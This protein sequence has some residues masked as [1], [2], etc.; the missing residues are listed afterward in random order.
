VFLFTV[1]ALTQI[2]SATP[3]LSQ[4]PQDDPKAITCWL[5]NGDRISGRFISERRT[6][7]RIAHSSIGWLSIKRKDIATCE[8]SDS[9]IQRR[10]ADILTLPGSPSITTL[11]AAFDSAEVARAPEMQ[12]VKMALVSGRPFPQEAFER[13]PVVV[14]LAAAVATSVPT[15]GWKR[16][17]TMSYTVSS[18][19]AN[20]SDLGFVGGAT[21]RAPRS[22]VAFQARRLLGKRNGES[23]SDFLAMNIRYDQALGSTSTTATT[24]P[25][26]FAESIYERDPFAKLDRRVVANTGFSIPLVFETTN[27]LALE[28]GMGINHE[29]NATRNADT[30]VG[31][32][33]RLA[34]RQTFGVAKSDQQISTFPDFSGQSMRYRINS[35]FNFVAPVSRM[36]SLRFGLTNRYNTRPQAN[37]KRSDT[38]LLS[39]LGFEF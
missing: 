21:R 5:T 12:P 38:T 1:L 15:V 30:R 34:A 13:P 8:A 26:F 9:T 39:G 17:L 4:P 18:G 2:G 28:V 23:S 19:N 27:N 6:Y 33:L 10:L 22:Q 36:M 37:V 11:D 16:T 31:G 3:P 29:K 24:R 7:V 35:D 25:S 14:P 32:V 20:T